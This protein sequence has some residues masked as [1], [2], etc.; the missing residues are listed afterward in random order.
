MG[1]EDGG[2][3]FLR[4]TQDTFALMGAGLRLL[5]PGQYSAGVEGW[6]ALK[7]DP[8]SLTAL[9]FADIT[10]EVL[11]AWATP[12]TVAQVISNRESP[13]HCD[14]KGYPGWYDCLLT[15]GKHE[16]TLLEVPAAGCRFVYQPG[17]AV[18]LLSNAVEHGVG[19]V[20]GERGCTASFMRPEVVS[21]FVKDLNEKVGIPPTHREVKVGVVNALKDL[22]GRLTRG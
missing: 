4:A 9:G 5:H 15:F 17:T 10:S 13:V 14:T 19:K 1:R 3:P 7:K 12:Y 11:N 21:Y 16:Q 8:Q 18:Y 22:Q 2:M 20:K 6:K